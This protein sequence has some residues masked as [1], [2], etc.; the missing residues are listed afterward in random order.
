MNTPD[1]ERRFVAG[2]QKPD[3]SL[4][5][6]RAAYIED[7]T[8]NLAKAAQENAEI[9]AKERAQKREIPVDVQSGTAEALF[10]NLRNTMFDNEDALQK[11]RG[12]KQR[13]QTLEKLRLE[14]ELLDNI[15]AAFA[16]KL[17]RQ[18]L[19]SGTSVTA[20]EATKRRRA[21]SANEMYDEVQVML[22]F[23]ESQKDN[24]ANTG[25]VPEGNA[26]ASRHVYE[27]DRLIEA[28]KSLQRRLSEEALKK[29]EN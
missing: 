22:D 2:P 15:G 29:G 17:I 8:G 1:Q 28:C 27:I 18:G 26:G 20:E 4:D 23:Y 11:N 9:R 14:L 25:R 12:D 13:E 21:L 6:S 10:F 5:T 19:E 16:A 24:G 3:G 7:P